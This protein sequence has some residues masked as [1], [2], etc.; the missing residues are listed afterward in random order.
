VPLKDGVHAA[1]DR[2]DVLGLPRA[3]ATSTAGER[4]APSSAPRDC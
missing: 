1:L 3:V 4:R 2:L